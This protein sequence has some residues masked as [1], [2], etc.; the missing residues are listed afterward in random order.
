MAIS[1]RQLLRLLP[2]SAA[3]TLLPS[4]STLQAAGSATGSLRLCTVADDAALPRFAAG[5]LLLADVACTSFAGAGLYFYPAWG[6]PR[7]YLVTNVPGNLL[8]FRNPGSGRLLWVQSTTLG[9]VFAARLAD[10][11]ATRATA[12]MPALQ[13]PAL[14]DLA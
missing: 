3:G 11:A 8:E 10:D 5:D 2:Y 13:V 12:G 4:L 14:P 6:T 1:R 9:A 7:P